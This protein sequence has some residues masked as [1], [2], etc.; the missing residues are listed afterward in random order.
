MT[1]ILVLG[2]ADW[3]QAIATNQHYVVRELA[4]G[5]PLTY[6]ES[7]GLRAPEL[8]WRDIKRAAKRLRRKRGNTPA[9][10]HRPVP[11]GVTVLSPKVLPRHVG[12]AYRINRPRVHRLVEDWLAAPGP[13]VLW[14]YTP[15]TY[16]LEQNADHVVYHCVDLLGQV[17]G[18]PAD[19]ICSSERH[20]AGLL[21]V[22]AIGTS[23]LV[24]QHLQSEGF[25][26]V[27][28]WPNVADGSIISANK[29]EAVD[30][31]PGRVVFAGNLSI[32]KVDF[33]LLNELVVAG[34]DLHLAGPI[35]EGGGGYAAAAVR[36]LERTGATYHGHLSLDEL[37]RLYWTA[38]VGLIPYRINS[39][40]RGVSPLKTY[41]YLAAG[42]AV[43]ATDLPG[44]LA[45]DPDVHVTTTSPQFMK[46]ATAQAECP[47]DHE[48]ERRIALAKLNSWDRRGEVAR[49]LVRELMA[50]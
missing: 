6:T 47:S 26:D 3:N 48:V 1:A 27:I 14:T 44:V 49:A 9:S 42:L 18:I 7:M 11:D 39:Y 17:E 22:Q 25:R 41:E 20:L 37:A 23:D 33:Q 15:V 43:V 32:H 10:D 13:R 35:A 21:K 38:T 36:D 4:K 5:F 40:T 24:R 46:L 34:C 12:A 31:V 19:L 29:P 30:R 8:S 45:A 28:Y 2:T 16:E 50:R